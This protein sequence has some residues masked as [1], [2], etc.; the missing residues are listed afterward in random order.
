MFKTF[1]LRSNG[2]IPQAVLFWSGTLLSEAIG[3]CAAFARP[4]PSAGFACSA[5]AGFSCADANMTG[6][7]RMDS[8]ESNFRLII[9]SPRTFCA[10]SLPRGTHVSAQC[11]LYSYERE[12][13]RPHRTH[14]RGLHRGRDSVDD[15]DAR[16]STPG[17]DG[18]GRIV[19]HYGLLVIPVVRSPDVA[20][21]VH[22]HLGN[23][24]YASALELVDDV[25]GLG[26]GGMPLRIFTRHQYDPTTIEVAEPDV[27]LA[28]NG[29]APWHVDRQAAKSVRRRMAAVGAGHLDDASGF[30]GSGITKDIQP[31]DLKLL[32]DLYAFGDDR[33]REVQT[34]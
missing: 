25:A 9:S 2:P 7:K 30:C 20:R 24:L 17:R 19:G 13:V 34:Y 31:G 23:H 3:F 22:R 16:T 12:S 32:H 6:K 28:V 8:N 14:K 4:S 10:G 29:K 27:V 5:G 15:G 33:G 1:S 21:R 26:A 18:A 11:L